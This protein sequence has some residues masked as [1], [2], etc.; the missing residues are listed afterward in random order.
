MN[1]R[2]SILKVALILFSEKGFHGTTMDE[3]A[4]RA[5]VA[6]GSIYTYFNS[7]QDLFI[8]IITEGFSVLKNKF[9][10]IAEKPVS[11]REKIEEAVSFY[12]DHFEKHRHF[13]KTILFE[14][15]NVMGKKISLSKKEEHRKEYEG[16]IKILSG[17]M[18]EGIESGEFKSFAPLIMAHSLMGM[19]DRLMFLSLLKKDIDVLSRLKE[20]ILKIYFKGILRED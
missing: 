4:K 19:V 6:K 3:I 1:R 18:Q 2:E 17:I 11:S 13:F 7:K 12:L 16:L 9:E 14:K 15:R 10:E 5:K 8:S 20:F